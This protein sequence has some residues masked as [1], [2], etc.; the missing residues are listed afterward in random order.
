MDYGMIGKL[1]KAKR[2]AEDR[3]RFRFDKFELTFRGDNNDHKVSYDHGIFTCDCEF[4]MTHKRCGHSM[5][6]E[7]LLKDMIIETVEE[8]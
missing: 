6:L 3:D 7:I 5:A 4:F 8:A 2:Y 1:E